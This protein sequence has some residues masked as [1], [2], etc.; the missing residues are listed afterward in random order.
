LILD[1]PVAAGDRAP[2]LEQIVARRGVLREEITETG[3]CLET[4]R[5]HERAARM[6][7]EPGMSRVEEDVSEAMAFHSPGPTGGG[8]PWVVPLGLDPA[9]FPAFPPARV[10]KVDIPKKA[11]YRLSIYHRCLQRLKDN[12]QE[13][14]SSSA[15]AKAAG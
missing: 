11:I 8:M 1:E 7:G 14:V 13:T 3:K 2:G 10:E 6:H 15:L 9:E 12:G 4:K 5:C